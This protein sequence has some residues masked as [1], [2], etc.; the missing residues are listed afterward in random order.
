ML[1]EYGGTVYQS[2]FVA[3]NGKTYLIRAFINDD[4]EPMIIKSVYITSK[5]NKYCEER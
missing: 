1:D 5:I 2:K 4:V 3:E